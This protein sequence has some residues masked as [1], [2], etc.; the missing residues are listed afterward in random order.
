MIKC[1]E[2]RTWAA[3]C[4]FHICDFQRTC[5]R[6]VECSRFAYSYALWIIITISTVSSAISPHCQRF[7]FQAILSHRIFLLKLMRASATRWSYTE[8]HKNY[9]KVW[10]KRKKKHSKLVRSHNENTAWW[11]RVLRCIGWYATSDSN[12]SKTVGIMCACFF[13][14]YFSAGRQQKDSKDSV[15]FKETAAKYINSTSF[16]PFRCQYNVIYDRVA[17]RNASEH[18]PKTAQRQ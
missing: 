13:L 10:N 4:Y 8:S 9:T 5:V 14:W 1:A 18:L 11:R 15:G 16:Q 17:A 2:V 6:G 7:T 12:Y 3:I